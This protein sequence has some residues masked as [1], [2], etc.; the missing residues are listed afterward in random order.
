MCV[1]IIRAN[2]E[3]MGFSQNF[4]IYDDTDSKR[5]VNEIMA[6]LDI[7]P[8][9]FP[10]NAI[11]NRISTAKNELK[12]PAAFAQEAIDPVGK[13]AALVYEK[14]QARLR[15]ANAFDFDDLLLYAYLLLKHHPDVLAAY[16]DR[17]RY[18]LVDEYQD[19]N[20]APVRAVPAP[21]GRAREHHGRR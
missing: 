11:R 2:A 15:E 10:I 3:T 7:D 1:R 5:L 21:C 9:R 6:E 17:F 14:L 13:R 18:I 20:H 4:T 8:K 16:Q 12:V 19:T